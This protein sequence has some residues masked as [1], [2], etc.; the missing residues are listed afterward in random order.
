MLTIY[1]GNR[2]II[3]KIYWRGGWKISLVLFIDLKFIWTGVIV[4]RFGQVLKIP[5]WE[6]E[7]F[8]KHEKNTDVSRLLD[9]GRC[10]RPANTAQE[11]STQLSNIGVWKLTIMKI[12]FGAKKRHLDTHPMCKSV[13]GCAL[14]MLHFKPVLALAHSTKHRAFGPALSAVRSYPPL[15]RNT[16]HNAVEHSA[17]HRTCTLTC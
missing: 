4:R 14:I 13:N 17:W 16:I 15:H 1:F 2:G 5:E 10:L 7:E 12:L 3:W 8:P 9:A 11:V 6:K